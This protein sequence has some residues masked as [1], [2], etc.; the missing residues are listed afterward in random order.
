MVVLVYGIWLALGVKI[1]LFLWLIE[2]SNNVGHSAFH[3][4][5]Y[6]PTYTKLSNKNI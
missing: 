2:M 3:L 5:L 6:I 1:V 4:Q